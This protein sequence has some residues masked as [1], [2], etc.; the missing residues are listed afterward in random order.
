MTNRRPGT[1]AGLLFLGLIL[2]LFAMHGPGLVGSPAIAHPVVASAAVQPSA[3]HA[4]SAAL[5]S[6]NPAP[7]H[8]DGLGTLLHLCVA[9]LTAAG[10]LLL[11][12]GRRQP[13][14]KVRGIRS[15]VFLP[16]IPVRRA[17]SSGRRR[18][19]ALNVSLT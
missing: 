19:I 16:D 10:L 13:C 2:G 7:A 14:H 1:R 9:V 12:T 11:G 8:P 18:L 17:P 4:D 6:E 5:E 15:G 3:S